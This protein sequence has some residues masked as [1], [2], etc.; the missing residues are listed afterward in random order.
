MNDCLH[1]VCK[2][3]GLRYFLAYGSL[4]GAV[5]HKGFIPWD[6]DM[7][8]VMLRDDFEKL[9]TLGAEFSSPYFLQNA[10]TDP[11]DGSPVMKIRNSNTTQFNKFLNWGGV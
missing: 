3:H 10:H 5:R 4:L 9:A 6:D 11:G 1:A 2:K 8:V 7:D